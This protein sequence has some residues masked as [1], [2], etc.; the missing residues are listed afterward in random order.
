MAM[1]PFSLVR[2]L[3]TQDVQHRV[4]LLLV[5]PA[6]IADPSPLLLKFN[7]ANADIAKQ[8]LLTL[9]VG[10]RALGI[11]QTKVLTVF[12]ELAHTR[13]ER[14]TLLLT[15]LDLMLARLNE[16]DR[17]GVW[18]FLRN[19]VRKRPTSVLIAFPD[20]A[21]HLLHPSE[22]DAW[23]VSGR[24]AFAPSTAIPSA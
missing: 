5:S 3:D 18:T 15:N 7:L 19:N 2:M 17:A 11:T 6:D 9:P 14:V 21:D 10:A 12:D 16:D 8:F 13:H 23:E 20:H 4:G 24:L 1:D 22:R